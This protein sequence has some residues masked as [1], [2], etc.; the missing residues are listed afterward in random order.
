MHI[1]RANEGMDNDMHMTVAGR[2]KWKRQGAAQF[3]DNE[4]G[5]VNPSTNKTALNYFVTNSVPAW[6]YSAEV[7]CVITHTISIIVLHG[8]SKVL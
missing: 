8:N 7:L 5:I 2:S 3:R 4:T 6:P 1:A